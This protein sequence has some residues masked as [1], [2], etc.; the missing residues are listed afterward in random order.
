MKKLISFLLCLLLCCA[1]ASFAE[2]S[3]SPSSGFSV[4]VMTAVCELLDSQNVNSFFLDNAALLSSLIG[5]DISPLEDDYQW[6]S[7]SN[8]VLTFPLSDDSGIAVMISHKNS[9]ISTVGFVYMCASASQATDSAFSVF[10]D[11]ELTD[12]DDT[13]FY[14]DPSYSQQVD[15]I[16]AC[17]PLSKDPPGYACAIRHGEGWLLYAEYTPDSPNL[18]IVLIA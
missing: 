10:T 2:A 3:A 6:L 16:S 7:Y 9:L 5:Q 12:E 1:P 13:S 8:D 15:F 18:F 4:D 17:V 14:A 11:L